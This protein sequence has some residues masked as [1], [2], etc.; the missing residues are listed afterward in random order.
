MRQADGFGPLEPY[1]YYRL[2]NGLHLFA[3]SV[4][5]RI[6]NLEYP[7]RERLVVFDEVFEFVGGFDLA[8]D[9]P[10]QFP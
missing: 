9:D 10:Y 5:S 6:C 4:E 8:V 2:C 3:A 7:D 1:E